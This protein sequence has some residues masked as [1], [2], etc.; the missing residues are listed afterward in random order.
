MKDFQLE[1]YCEKNDD[2]YFSF[3]KKTV[4]T[5]LPLSHFTNEHTQFRNNTMS[6]RNLQNLSAKMLI[7]EIKSILKIG[8][9]H[10]KRDSILINLKEEYNGRSKSSRLLHIKQPFPLCKRITL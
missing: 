8:I 3:V 6:E 9:K 2:F 4:G 1:L 7:F 10:T 5:W